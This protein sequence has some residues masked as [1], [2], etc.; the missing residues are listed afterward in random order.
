MKKWIITALLFLS[1]SPILCAFTTV[2]AE[3]VEQYTLVKEGV[4]QCA[5]VLPPNATT[6]MEYGANDVKEHL[7]LMSGADVPI[8]KQKRDS[9]LP[10]KYPGL[11]M[12]ANGPVKEENCDSAEELRITTKPGKPWII[13][14][15]GDRNRGAMYGCYAFLQDVLGC[16]WFTNSISRIPKQKTITVGT[17][18]IHQRPSFELRDPYYWESLVSTKWILRNRINGS[19]CRIPTACKIQ[20][21]SMIAHTMFKLVPPK[22][23]FDSHPEYFSLVN[24]KRV[25]DRQLCL[26]NPAVLKIAIAGV[27]QWLKKNPAANIVSVAQMDNEG[28][29][30]Q[31]ENCRKIKEREDSESGPIL[32]FVNA[33]AKEIGKEYPNVLIETLAYNYSAKS[34]KYVKPLPNVRVRLCT[35]WNCK[36]HRLDGNC[37]KNSIDTYQNL[38]AWNKITQQLYIWDYNTEFNDYM[39]LHPSLDYTKTIFDIFHKV[40]VI[41]VFMQGSYQSPSGSLAEIKAYLCARLMWDCTLNPDKILKEYIDG[42][43]GKSAPIISEWI[44]LIHSPFKQ[45]TSEKKHL[46]IYDK[47]NAAFL[48]KEILDKSDELIEK[49]LAVSADEPLVLEEIGKIRMWVDYTRIAQIKLQTTVQK[50]KYTYGVS[51]KNLDRIDRWLES[52]K[53]YNVTHLRE[54]KLCDLSNILTHKTAEMNCLSLENNNLRLDILPT[55]G[56]KIAQ[57]RDKK[58]GVNLMLSPESI[59]HK[60]NGGYEEYV[61]EK[62]RGP[63]FWK[64]NYVYSIHNNSIILKGTTPTGREITKQFTLDGNKLF[65]KTSV[66]NGTDQPISV[67]IWESPQFSLQDFKDAHVSFDKID[68]DTITLSPKD[69]SINWSELSKEYKGNSIPSGKVVLKIKNTTITNEFKPEN[70]DYFHVWNNGGRPTKVLKLELFAKRV[71]L[72]PNETTSFEQHWLIE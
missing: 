39:L 41:G 25:P 29:A 24:G 46:G 53:H 27:K 34:P 6:S 22:K 43:Y 48:T 70:L 15:Y 9:D 60:D 12:L 14:I 28:G 36:A 58:N 71:I 51:N 16:R 47:P 61:I 26:T 56:G 68:G 67:K 45:N 17:L 32:E 2:D 33:I 50:G 7:K 4:S 19:Q 44:T 49:A 18:N 69:F 72:Q 38:L 35:A 65:L 3:T 8:Y 13:R 31:C 54:G 63:E 37:C 5:I 30:C 10:V 52:L 40:G 21:G 66:K 64:I 20:Y 42:V 55:L 62:K 57:L 1:I 59:F 23:Y 11:I